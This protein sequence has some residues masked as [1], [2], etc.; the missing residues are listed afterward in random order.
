MTRESNGK[1]RRNVTVKVIPRQAE[2]ALG[3]PVRLRPQ[4]ISTFGTTRV[5]GRQ[6]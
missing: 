2:E 6:P 3:V 5:V 1:E 4:T